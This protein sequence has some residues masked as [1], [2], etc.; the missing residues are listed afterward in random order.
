[1]PN[2]PPAT[3]PQAGQRLPVPEALQLALKHQEAGRLKESEAILRR[4][5]RLQPRNAFANH[6]LGVIAHQTGQ[7][8][9]AVKLI[10]EAIAEQPSVSLFHTNLCEMLRQMGRTDEAIEHGRRGVELAP[11]WA[12]AISN[13]GMALFADEDYDGA[14]E[15]QQRAL[16]RD[17]QLLLALHNLASIYRHR[18][19]PE[20]AADYY[21]RAI[22]AVPGHVESLNNLGALLIEQERPEEAKP[23]L[24]KAVQLS[25]QYAEAHRNLGAVFLMENSLDKARAAFKEALK[26]NPEF[27]EAYLGLGTVHRETGDLAEAEE[28]SQRALALDSGSVAAHSQLGLLYEDMGYPEKALASFDQ[29]ISVD[30]EAEQPRVS[31]A[32]LLSH[33]GDVASAGELLEATLAL[34]PESMPARLAMVHLRR[35]KPE[36]ET[37]AAL[38]AAHA[39]ID[40]LSQAKQAP[41]HFG[42]GKCYDDLGEHERAFEHYLQGCA[43][44]RAKM[45][46]DITRNTAFVARIMEA[47]GQSAIERA[48][49][50]GDPCRLPIFVLGMPRSGTTLTEQ[51]IASHSACYGA[52]ELGDLSQIANQHRDSRYPASI[53]DIT[54]HELADLG[55]AY[56]AG[57]KARNPD[58]ARIT[59]KMPANFYFVGLI[60][61]MLPNAKIIHVMRNPVDTCVSGLSKLF[62]Y[63]HFHS[64]NLTEQGQYYVSY[65]RLMKHWRSVLPA[66]AYHE[67]QYEALVENTDVEARAL[68]DYCELEWEPACL[69]FHKTER[70]VKTASATQVRQP[71]YKTSLERWRRYEKHLGPLFDALGDLAPVRDAKA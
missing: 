35:V 21:R 17:P 15:C 26:L 70:V 28:A 41:L 20:R 5:L 59:D 68:I 50:A 18:K 6:L 37:L 64:Y 36:D 40:T 10:R 55:T 69:D 29:A 19:D 12:R 44:K 45:D 8:E 66:T 49:G 24:L 67:V 2:S 65:D 11:N 60:H 32:R 31:K 57:L 14:E 54:K 48:Q 7:F 25:P 3:P 34:N 16:A 4:I 13:L 30:L 1:M 61:M 47:I 38:E 33:L 22:A 71:I 62:T 23:L 9:L 27:A 42:L 52:G 63:G 43:L 51:I 58:A 46:F 39:R 53:L 56:V